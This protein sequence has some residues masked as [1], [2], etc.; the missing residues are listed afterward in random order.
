MPKPALMSQNQS[1]IIDWVP[2]PFDRRAAFFLFEALTNRFGRD[3]CFP[4]FGTGFEG[5]GDEGFESFKGVLP[6]GVLGAISLRG[7][8]QAS[9]PV[10][11]GGELFTQARP[12]EIA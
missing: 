3:G 7:Q 8:M 9:V 1:V 10:D 4:P 11:P 2:Q 5:L 12:L 6:I